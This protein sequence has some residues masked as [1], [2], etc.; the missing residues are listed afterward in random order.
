MQTLIEKIASYKLATQ[1]LIDKTE[2][3]EEYVKKN[4]PFEFW[5]NFDI[6]RCG[7]GQNE[8]SCL[9]ISNKLIPT[10]TEDLGKGT[11]WANDFNYWYDYVTG[12]ELIEWAKQLPELLKKAEE[13]IANLTKEAEAVS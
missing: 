8:G 5:K 2:E 7:R 6:G 12:K 9:R 1:S 13:L 3:F 11:Y 4:V 10:C